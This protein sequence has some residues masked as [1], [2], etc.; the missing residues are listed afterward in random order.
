MRT[1]PA[2]SGLL[3]TRFDV[4][5]A[6]RLIK[7]VVVVWHCFAGD[8]GEAGIASLRRSNNPN[9][10]TTFASHV[11][12]IGIK[13]VAK[14]SDYFVTVFIRIRFQELF[15]VL[16]EANGLKSTFHLQLSSI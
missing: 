14:T 3:L 2:T 15:D 1:V 16:V 7:F 9:R 11:T 5:R 6:A 4:L 8:A 10:G 12:R 13:G